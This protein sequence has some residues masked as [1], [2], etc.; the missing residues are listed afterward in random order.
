MCLFDGKI[1][2]RNCS[3]R[4]L[5]TFRNVVTK[6]L[7]KIWNVFAY[8]S[9]LKEW[10]SYFRQNN[11]ISYGVNAHNKENIKQVDVALPLPLFQ[12]YV[13]HWSI[14]ITCKR[15]QTFAPHFFC[16]FISMDHFCT[17]MVS[18]VLPS[19]LYFTLW[20]LMYWLHEYYYCYYYYYYYLE[21]FRQKLYL[22]ELHGINKHFPNF[23]CLN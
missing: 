11:C 13:W 10:I 5:H 23:H 7:L 19:Y 15:K 17:N 9:H 2:M 4:T 14:W 3:I 22:V 8:V 16:L 20:M 1:K 18:I 21:R 12:L 6:F